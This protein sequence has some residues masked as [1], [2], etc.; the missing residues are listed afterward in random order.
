MSAFADLKVGTKVYAIVGFLALVATAIAAFGIDAMRTYDAKVEQITHASQ[1][2]LLGERINALVLAVVMDSRGIYMARNREEAEKF[3]KPLLANI[4][5]MDEQFATWEGL[6]LDSTRADFGATR[7]E[8]KQFKEFRTELV[9]LGYEQGSSAAREYGDNDANRTNRQALNGKIQ[10][11]AAANDEL[12][13]RLYAELAEYYDFRSK[14]MIGGA[15]IGII[16]ALFIAV[17]VVMRFVTRPIAAMTDAMLTLAEGDVSVEIPCVGRTDEIGDMANAVQ[18]FKDN[19]IETDRLV[20]QEQATAVQQKRA[21][22]IEREIA[23]FDDV[24]KGVLKALLDSG[25]E[26]EAA[27]QRMT[28]SAEATNVQSTAVASA[29]EQTSANVQTVASATDELTSSISEISRQMSTSTE[30]MGTAVKEAERASEMVQGLAQAAEKIGKVVTLI[31]DIAE[32]TNLLALNATIEAARAGDAGKGFAVVASEV[33]SLAN[34]TAKATE[35]IGAQISSIQ[36]AT[37]HS[38][39]A[40]TGISGTIRK[41]NEITGT[42]AAAVEQQSAATQEIAQNIEQAA[43]GTRDVTSNIAGVT[44]SVAQSSDVS[45]QVLNSARELTRQSE[46]LRGRVDAFLGEMKAA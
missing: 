42:V 41:I 12:I 26:L 20:E 28:A 46:M 45:V 22:R 18:V 43:T 40:I 13:G 34:Q 1:R 14:L 29:A 30:V 23:Q 3:G 31:T 32:Q 19:K 6:I 25:A 8:A 44:Q 2:A 10:K 15:V 7:A 35:E 39:E 11:L 21:E 9:R 36:S 37:K 4:K 27:A 33:K 38:V 5:S 24:I 16:S 17:F